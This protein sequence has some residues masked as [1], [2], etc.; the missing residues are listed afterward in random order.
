MSI[1]IDVPVDLCT[2]D[3]GGISS[4]APVLDIF[5]PL[6]AANISD[7]NVDERL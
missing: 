5:S 6:T 2:D 7:T 1:E 3:T 4:P